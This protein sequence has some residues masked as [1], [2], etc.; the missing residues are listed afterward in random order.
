MYFAWDGKSWQHAEGWLSYGDDDDE[1]KKG[2]DD[3][4]LSALWSVTKHPSDVCLW[5]GVICRRNQQ[6]RAVQQDDNDDDDKNDDNDNDA[7]FGNHGN[8]TTNESGGDEEE[9]IVGLDLSGNHLVGYLA[10]VKELRWLGEHLETLDLSDNHLEGPI[11]E[12]LGLLEQLIEL[13]LSHNDLSGSLPPA[14][15]GNLSNL[16]VL[17]VEDNFLVAGLD[18]RNG[19]APRLAPPLC[20]AADN[21]K[22]NDNANAAPW[23]ILSADCSGTK[24]G[25]KCPCCTHCCSS[26][27]HHHQSAGSGLRGGPATREQS[28]IGEPTKPKPKPKPND[29]ATTVCVEQRRFREGDDGN[30]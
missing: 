10:A 23:T 20:G 29:P 15:P 9:T 24:P 3:H 19:G 2:R 17:R 21:A 18:G 16:R 7:V 27:N 8:A 12:D 6:R 5:K 14:V 25:V 11:P 13:D 1:T 28:P 22:A 4:R 26:G 30:R